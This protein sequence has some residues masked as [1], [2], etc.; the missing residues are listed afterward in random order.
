[1]EHVILFANEVRVNKIR[2]GETNE[3]YCSGNDAGQTADTILTT[4]LFT[5]ERVVPLF[6]SNKYTYTARP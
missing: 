2:R 1:M 3:N 5:K 4:I 6:A